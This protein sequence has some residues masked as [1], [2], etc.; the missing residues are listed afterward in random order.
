[1]KSFY[2]IITPFEGP[3]PD[4]SLPGDQ[5]EVGIPVF[6]TNPIVIPPVTGDGGEVVTPPIYIPP[7]VTIPIF[8]TNPTT[9]YAQTSESASSPTV[10]TARR[11]RMG[12]LRSGP[13]PPR[14]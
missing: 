14:C 2:A 3:G 1:M 9:T 13:V 8:P 11:L 4:T 5:P 12:H 6:P 7:E 10:R